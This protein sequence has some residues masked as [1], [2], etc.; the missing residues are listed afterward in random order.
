VPFRRSVL[1]STALVGSAVLAAALPAAALTV[2]VNG[3][4]VAFNPA[5]ISRAGRVFVPLRGVFERLGASV[6]YERGLINATGNN[7]AISLRIGSTQATIDGQPRAVDVAPFVIGA[8]TYVPLRFVSQ[9]LGA[10]VNYDAANQIVALTTSG[11]PQAAPPPMAAQP[12]PMGRFLSA[13]E[14]ERGSVVPSRKPT[15]SAN[16]T[17]PADPNSVRISL[18]GLN[19]TSGATRSASGFIY[20]PPSPLQSMKHTVVAMGN[21]ASGGPFSD[22]WSFTS[23]TQVAVNTLS[24]TS[25][26][27][28]SAVGS[29]FTVIGKT[30]ANAHV[31]IVAGATASVA[32]VFAYGAGTYT[33][34]VTAD[35]AGNFSQDVTLQTVGGATI[36]MTLTST[37]PQTK[38]SAEKK[39]HLSVR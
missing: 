38:E 28:G 37:D 27:D 10:G 19:V 12:M 33:G 32:G 39:L 5:P 35:G 7:H 25:P 20:A 15:I 31:H 34:D 23:G 16:F 13:L 11:Q 21:L 18:D 22:R 36:A 9:A 14:P 17:Q 26:S 24:I 3:Q 29:T 1:I 30:V 6:V 2:S 4:T 8:S